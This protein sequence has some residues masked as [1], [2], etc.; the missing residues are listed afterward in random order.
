MRRA[1]GEEQFA[2]VLSRHP[3]DDGQPEPGASTVTMHKRLAYVLCSGTREPRPFIHHGNA[4]IVA[5]APQL[6]RE[7]RRTMPLRV[8]LPVIG[9]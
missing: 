9:A 3:I 8:D 2:A 6:Q 4:P 5:V 7:R 1:I